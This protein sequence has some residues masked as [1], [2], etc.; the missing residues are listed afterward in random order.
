V[1]DGQPV[2]RSQQRD[3]KLIDIERDNMIL[4]GICGKARSGK[5]TAANYLCTNYG[6]QKYSLA[7]PIRRMLSVLMVNYGETDKE[8]PNK[9]F[10]KSPREMMQTLGTE[11]MR[12]CV[13]E[14]GWL[15]LAIHEYDWLAA[16]PSCQG[17]SVADIR[18]SNEATWIRQ[19]G[20]LIHM[21]RPDAIPVS[22][23]VSENGIE[24]ESGDLRINND[25]DIPSL[26]RQCDMAMEMIKCKKEDT[27]YLSR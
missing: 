12:D 11:W 25:S 22:E 16:S 9:V 13:N 17:M 3:L 21:D 24:Y 19:N 2:C 23:H 18:F 1:Q 7:D 10:G 27:Q 20:I 5:D 4:V 14:N 8:T 26:Y 6:L 15:L